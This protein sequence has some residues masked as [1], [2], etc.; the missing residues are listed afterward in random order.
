MSQMTIKITLEQ[1]NLNSFAYIN[2]F[3]INNEYI[4]I[5]ERKKFS[6]S[7]KYFIFKMKN[8]D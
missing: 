4:Y 6:L 8:I 2:L 1:C 3:L 5:Y 7:E